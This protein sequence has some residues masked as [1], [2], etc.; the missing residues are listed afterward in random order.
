[1]G[2]SNVR[3][4]QDGT[5]VVLRL[6]TPDDTERLSG[7]FSRLSREARQFLYDDVTDRKVIES[8]TMGVNYDNVV[9]IVALVDDEIVADG[10]LHKRNNGP[11]RHMG[12]IRV[13][14][15][16]DCQGKGLGSIIMGEL[17]SIGKARKLVYLY[18]VLAERGEAIA[19]SACER[20]GFKRVA[21]LPN[22]LSDMAGT[23]ED[24]IVMVKNI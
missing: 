6:L 7:F 3:K 21:K 2:K 13:I 15:R 18:V 20:E 1:M 8:W 11:S 4:L 17:A 24:G 9:P 22:F 5:E 12:R 19:I 14:V 23:L 16:E 10:T